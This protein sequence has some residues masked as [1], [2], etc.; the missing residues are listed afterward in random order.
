MGVAPYAGHLQRGTSRIK[1]FVGAVVEQT[2]RRRRARATHR[3]GERFIGDADFEPEFVGQTA[4]QIA[5]QRTAAGQHD[6]AV[7]DIRHQFRGRRFKRTFHRADHLPQ[8]TLNRIGDIV[9]AQLHRAR[10]TIVDAAPGRVHMFDR[11][12]A[13]GRTDRKSVV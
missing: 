3:A 12:L 11:H 2:G 8:R 1:S 6:T 7:R 5:K 4:T 9:I 13:Q 10:Q